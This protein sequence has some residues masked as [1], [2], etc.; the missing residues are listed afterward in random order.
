MF[1]LGLF[2]LGLRLHARA[3]RDV[4]ARQ[5]GAP[6]GL[7]R[8]RRAA[9]RGLYGGQ[10]QILL[11][12]VAALPLLFGLTLL[13]PRPSVGGMA[14]TLLGIYWIGFALAH[15]VLLRGLPHGLGH[16]DRRARGHVPRRHR[17]LPRRA[18]CS[19]AVRS[20]RDLA[21]QDRRGAAD[22]DGVR[23]ARRVDRGALSGLAAGHA[24]ARARSRRRAGR[25]R[26]ATCSSR[27]SS[28]RRTPRTPAGCS[29]PTAGRS[30]ASTRCCS[31]SSSAT[32]SGR[33]TC[34]GAQGTAGFC[35]V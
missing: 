16:R 26:W 11:V 2:V 19:G 18:A 4:R 15:A 31:R 14:L 20:R 3:V 24:R 29:A 28:A 33:R 1:T 22:R 6:G 5:A 27:S 7:P 10:F 35:G 30:T 9:R 21:E 13:Q 34:T 8:A 23:G 25:R 12:A 32:T 17:R